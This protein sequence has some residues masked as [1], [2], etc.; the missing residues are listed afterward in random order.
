M[1]KLNRDGS[2]LKIIGKRGIQLGGMVRPKGIAV[3]RAGRLY[4]ADAA[5]DSV[6]IFNEEGELLLMMGGPGFGPGD[7]SLPAKVVIS[8]QGIEYFAR[9][10]SPDFRVE[11]LIFV[12][13]HDGPNRINVYGFGT[14]N[15]PLPAPTETPSEEGAP[16]SVVPSPAPVPAETTDPQ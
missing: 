7:M 12:T 14:Y 4:V 3:D 5:T 15:A 8:Y 2:L 9:H 11:Y 6:Q 13:N 10:A 16:S 1:Q